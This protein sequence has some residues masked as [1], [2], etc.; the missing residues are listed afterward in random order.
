MIPLNSIQPGKEGIISQIYMSD[1]LYKRLEVLGIRIGN[2]IKGI[3]THP[4]GGP[5]V[6]EV[7]RTQI[8]IGK[9]IAKK[10]FIDDF[11]EKI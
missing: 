5:V 10:I 8:S 7:D 1:I 2:K 9:G 3:T 6:I 11:K 4:F